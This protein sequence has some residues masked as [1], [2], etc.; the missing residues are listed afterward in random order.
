MLDAKLL[1][2]QAEFV[3]ARLQCRHVELDVAKL[4]AFDEQRKVLQSE[5]ESLQAERNAG[6]KKIGAAKKSG[7]DVAPIMARMQ[8]VNQRLETVKVELENLQA[9]ITAFSM[10]IPNLPHDSVPAGKG[11]ED[12]VE[13]RRWG[14]ITFG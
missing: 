11:E 4:H 5:T 13:V 3:A 9:E 14:N 6:A 2:T 1:R 10:A 7:E 8:E 12:N